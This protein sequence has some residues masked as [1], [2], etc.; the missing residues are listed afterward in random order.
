MRENKISNLILLLKNP[1]KRAVLL[2]V[3]IFLMMAWLL[4]GLIPSAS[5][6]QITDRSLTLGSGVPSAS[7]SYTFAFTTATGGFHLD[8]I[9]LI[10][11]SS[12]IGSYPGSTCAAPAGFSFTSAT[13]GSISG[14]TDSTNFTIDTT[15][16]NDCVATSHPEILCLKRTSS[17]ND[18]AAAKTL[19]INAVV[20]PSTPNTSFYIGVTT[21]NAN[22]W[23]SGGRQDFGATAAAVVQTL[24]TYAAVAELLQF[25]A[26]STNVNDVSTSIAADCSGMTGTSINL[27]TLDSSQ[28]SVSPVNTN[29][30][31]NQNGTVMVRSNAGNG[32]VI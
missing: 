8:A 24:S 23:P 11:C 12:A 9:K 19:I 15:G 7:T 13:Y 20:N 27:G 28:V 30:G 4:P 29:G 32:V 26:G 14:F 6:A 18:T 2:F 21:Y 17:S 10:A 16:A 31:D 22:T 1:L 25:C 3:V 5:A